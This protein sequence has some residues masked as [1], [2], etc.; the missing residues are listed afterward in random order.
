MLRRI[1]LLS[2]QQALRSVALVLFPTAFLSLTAW[3]T[4]GSSAGN[5]TD[6][7]RASL[8]FWLGAH[9]VPFHLLLPPSDIPGLLS[10][11]P[12]GALVFPFLALRSSFNRLS[13]E[14]ENVRGARVF[15]S[16]IYSGITSGIAF[17]S[18]THGVRPVWFLATAFSLIL[19]L[20]ATVD[21]NLAGLHF[22]KFPAYV[23][24]FLWGMG[25]VA[26]GLSLAAHFSIVKDLTTVTHP[27]LVG[28]AL[29]L[30]LQILYLPNVAISAIS[31]ASGFG[32]SLGAGTHISP[33]H[34][35]LHE[36]PA[37]PL[38]GS[39]PTGVHKSVGYLALLGVLASLIIVLNVNS[40]HSGFRDRQISLLKGTLFIGLVVGTFSY[41]ASGELITSAMSPVG[42][43]WWKLAAAAA[44]SILASATLTQYLPLAIGKVR[45]RG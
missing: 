19:A 45:A 31:Y 42:T 2:L 12:I 4:A 35:S 27:G 34:F 21:F 33:R 26:V 41:L 30:L 18:G 10:Y 6:P 17:L 38:L 43:I 7:V 22:V 1:L 23:L 8:W 9:Q 5:T 29:F 25:A 40:R 3:A 37:I 20:L 14:I 15:F 39:L 16:L 36:L 32:F 44:L 13:A 11:L 24:S 28:G